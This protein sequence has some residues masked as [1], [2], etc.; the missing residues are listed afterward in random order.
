MLENSTLQVVKK[1]QSNKILQTDQ[2]RQNR[3]CIVQF[4]FKENTNDI[5]VHYHR[6]CLYTEIKVNIKEKDEL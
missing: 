5:S 6:Q 3:L 1:C 2:V 4:S